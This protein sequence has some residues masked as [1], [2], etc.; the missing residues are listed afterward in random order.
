MKKLLLLCALSFATVTARAQAARPLLPVDSLTH[1]VTYQGVVQVPGASQADLYVRAR[2]WFATSFGSAKA[3]LEMD[4]KEAGK[5]I[6][7]A[8]GEYMQRFMGR[9]SP[10]TLWR[11]INIQVKDGRFKY[12]ISNFAT[13][14]NKAQADARPVEL[15]ITPAAFDKSGK[16]VPYMESM[17]SGIQA[18]AEAQ[19]KSLLIAM[20]SAKG[21]DW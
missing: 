21:K 4:D 19:V 3:V 17:L 15:A 7:N 8:H 6:G 5:L 13:G 11:T 1:K 9:E 14:T 18:S 2:E 16:L 10:T 20:A 12:T